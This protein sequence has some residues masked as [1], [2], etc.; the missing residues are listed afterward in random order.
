MFKIQNIS[1]SEPYNVFLKYLEKAKEKNQHPID[2][3]AINSYNIESN[4]VESRFVNLKFIID[5]K[6]IFFTNYESPK[7]K[8]F[9]THKQIAS[10]FYWQSINVQIRLK[11]FV[12]MIDKDFSDDYFK[13]RKYEK[14]I[15]SVSS[16]QSRK[17]ESYEQV[18]NNYEKTLKDDKLL[19]RPSYWGGY[20]F[21]PYYFEFWEGHPSRINKRECYELHGKD[22]KKSFLEP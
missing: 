22:W 9:S 12:E 17:I 10:T 14:N 21:R 19:V 16:K 6:W 8:Q 7:A 15:L 18:K 20:F 13:N 5:D 4:E 11:S 3:V 2:A 1:K